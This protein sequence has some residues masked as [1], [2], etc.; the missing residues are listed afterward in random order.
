M[1]KKNYGRSLPISQELH[2]E[3][4]RGE[5]ESFYQ[6]MTRIANAVA[7]NK[8]H[9][10][11]FREALLDQRF[12]PGGRVQAAVGAA[13]VVT[14]YNCFVSGTIED[15]M[16]SIMERA[17]EAAQTM[18]LGGGIGYDFSRLRPKGD[19]IATLD[20]Y[21]SRP[22]SFMGSFDAICQTI[23]AAGHRRGA[24]MAVLRVDHPD[25]ELF[26]RAKQNSDK[27]TA[28]NISV[29]VTDEF[30][31]AVQ[32]GEKFPLKFEGRIYKTVD[33]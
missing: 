20:S 28:F 24:Q 4:H 26:I 31:R 16:S 11:T 12:L 32:L 7:D 8:Q 29:G 6:A 18:R 3:K 21:S 5:G 33:A 9:F 15:S 17:C 13:R 10:Y 27:L 22:V 30:M 23:A 14:P 2:A 19:L 25:I 1:K